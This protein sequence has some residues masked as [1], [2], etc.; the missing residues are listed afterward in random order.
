MYVCIYIYIYIHICIHTCIYIYIHTYIYIYIYTVFKEGSFKG[1]DHAK[2]T[3]TARTKSRENTA[4]PPFFGGCPLKL[5][6]CSL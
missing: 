6:L 2:R 3:R 5:P 4:P 1:R